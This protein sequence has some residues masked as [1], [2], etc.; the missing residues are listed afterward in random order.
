MNF[1][2]HA[3]LDTVGNILTMHHKSMTCDASFSQGIVST[4]FM[5]GGHVFM[6]VS[7]CL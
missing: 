6:Y 4:L 2:L 7:C 1:M 3:M 5:E